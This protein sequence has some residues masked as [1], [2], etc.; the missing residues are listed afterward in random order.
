MKHARE[1]YSPI[2]D[3]RQG[4]ERIPDDEPVFLIRGQDKAGAGTVRVW[5]VLNDL[6]GG[7]PRASKKARDHADQMDRW[8]AKKL[9]DLPRK[10]DPCTSG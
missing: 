3:P 4:I 2:Q 8:P 1:D 5:A 9:A 6:L 7:D 10:E